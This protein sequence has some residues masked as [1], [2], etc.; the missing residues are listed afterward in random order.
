MVNLLMEEYNVSIPIMIDTMDNS[1]QN[2]YNPWPDKAY[3]FVNGK[4]QYIAKMNND[5]TRDHFW[6]TE[7]EKIF[8]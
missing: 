3:V 2:A 7:I 8:F 1:F 5:G 4:I 6:T